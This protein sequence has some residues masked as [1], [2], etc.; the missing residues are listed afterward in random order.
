MGGAH[1]SYALSFDPAI[2]N[3]GVSQK[4]SSILSTK[5]VQSLSVDDS[6]LRGSCS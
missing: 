2:V 3:G 4:M 6:H 5:S 1:F